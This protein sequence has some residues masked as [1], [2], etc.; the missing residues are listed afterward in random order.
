MQAINKRMIE[1][2]INGCQVTLSF[3]DEPVDSVMK[4]IKDILSNAYEE[5]VQKELKELVDK[6]L[7]G[8]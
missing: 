4:C 2:K 7:P 6:M 3:L 1:R 5:R 8:E